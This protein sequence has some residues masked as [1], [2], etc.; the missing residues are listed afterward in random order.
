MPGAFAASGPALFPLSGI[1]YCTL[2]L[3]YIASL[4]ALPL[5]LVRDTLL[6]CERDTFRSVSQDILFY[7]HLPHLKFLPHGNYKKLENVV[8]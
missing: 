4:A 8:S 2:V 5:A 3:R 6:G 1:S 7:N